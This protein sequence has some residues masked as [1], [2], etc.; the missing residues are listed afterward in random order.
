MLTIDAAKEISIRDYLEFRGI[1]TVQTG[2]KWFC[3]S[4]FSKDSNW[5][6]AIY[7]NNTFYCWSTGKGGDIIKLVQYL[8]GCNFRE[9]L[10]HLSADRYTPYKFNYIKF[11]EDDDFWKDFDIKKYKNNNEDEIKRII[12]Y[13]QSRSICSGFDCGVYF[14]RDFN[15]NTWLRNPALMFPHQDM[16][17]NIIG[18]KFRNIDNNN[19]P[20]F[21]TRGR[22]GFYIL[23]TVG[24]SSYQ[25]R[26]IWLCES[27]TSSNSL[28]EYFRSTNRSATIISMGGVSSAPKQ[29][30]TSC[31]GMSV[32]L[33]IDYDGNE[34]LYQER[35]S[36]Y[37]H[38]NIKPIKIILPKGEDINSLYHTGRMWTIENLLK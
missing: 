2:K 28:W 27:E 1:K 8:E 16:D 23:N 26:K 14:T 25:E 18:A 6:F 32:S 38:L 10:N 29:L 34:K 17:G 24:S 19:N 35:L 9:A 12:S 21:T 31:E 4:P 3:S 15:T 20:R 37:E 13:G 7:P 30:P 22:L 33:I 5:S 11:K 36:K